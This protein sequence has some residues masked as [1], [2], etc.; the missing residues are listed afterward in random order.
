MNCRRRARFGA[1]IPAKGDREKPSLRP[2]PD[3]GLG[4]AVPRAWKCRAAGLE[5]TISAVFNS[6]LAPV[7]IDDADKARLISF[8][9]DLSDYGQRQAD[10]LA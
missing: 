5:M 4:N 7:F 2:R 3:L 10:L 6:H 9:A 8:P 1:I